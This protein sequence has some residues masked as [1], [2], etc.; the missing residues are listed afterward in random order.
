MRL[1]LIEVNYPEIDL[2]T[3]FFVLIGAFNAS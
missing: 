2:F 1:Y 3:W